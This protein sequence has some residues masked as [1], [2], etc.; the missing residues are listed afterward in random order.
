MRR[1]FLARLAVA[2]LVGGLLSTAAIGS[3]SAMAPDAYI[4]AYAPSAQTVQQQYGVPA[5]VALGQSILESAWGE[6]RLTRERR[7]FFGFKCVSPSDPGPIATSCHNYPTQECDSSGCYTV[8]Q[9]FR[10]YASSTDSFRD[11][12]RLLRTPRYAAAFDHVDDPDQFIRE[13]HRAGYATDPEYANKVISLMRT[14]N[15]YRFNS[16]RNLAAESVNGDRYEDLLA[17]DSG[18]VL[19]SYP[20]RSG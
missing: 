19:W 8:N 12:G 17:V 18:N 2:A 14:Y 6:S 3:A 7:N 16:A 1:T 13:V 4:S 10:G 15:L 5:S 11:Y 9:Y 20:G